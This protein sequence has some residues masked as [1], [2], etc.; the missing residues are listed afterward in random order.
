[1]TGT[2]TP[3]Q[4]DGA[5]Y[6]MIAV[7][8]AVQTFF[9]SDEAYKYINAYLLFYIKCSAGIVLAGV[10]ALK[11]FRSTTY[12]DHLKD[13]KIAEVIKTPENG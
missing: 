1:M 7:C 2:I 10:G 8:G 11:M 5:L 13:K 6:I 3:A 9:S 4:L 12:S